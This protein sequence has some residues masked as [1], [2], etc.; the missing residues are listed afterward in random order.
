MNFIRK[1]FGGSDPLVRLRRALEQKRWAEAL[2]VGDGLEGTL[3][4]PEAK[5][6]LDALL[7]AAGDGLAEL[8]LTEGEA[9][10]RAGETA[11]AAEHFALAAEQARSPELRQRVMAAL[12]GLQQP[13]PAPLHPTAAASADCHSGCSVTCGAHPGDK[14]EEY[15]V[16]G[17]DPQTRL[18]LILASY[19]PGWADRYK[20]LTGAFRDAF[21]LAHEGREEEALAA[22]EGVPA[23]ERS[24]LFFFER[25][26]LRGRLG[27][28]TKATDDLEKAL[29]LNADHFLAMETLVHMELTM[30][31]ERS[32]ESRLNRM[33]S[34][35]F[36]PAFCHGSL[37]VIFARRGEFQAALDHGL[38]AIDTG[39]AGAQTFQL[40]ATLLEKD[41]RVVEAERVLMG[42]SGGGCSAGPNLPLAE[43]WLRHGKNL[44]KALESFKGG[45]RQEPGNPRWPLRVAQVYLARGWKKEGIGLLEKVLSAPGLESPLRDEAMA[46]LDTCRTR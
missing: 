39:E 27:D 28:L 4:S 30:G 15:D 45:L 21:L 5:A 38:Q 13:V 42:L 41:G 10:I 18:E 46:L 31:E 14:I 16:T 26:A 43:F 2:A 3:L 8:N 23:E 12:P 9:F 44:D 32:A 24:D 7:V 35:N 37:A 11:R 6:E 29:K 20:K 1:L 17:L 40:V 25:G 22:F 36:A 19:P 34:K 33:L